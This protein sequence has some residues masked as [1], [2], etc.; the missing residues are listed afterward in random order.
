MPDAL[1]QRADIYIQPMRILRP[2]TP[3]FYGKRIRQRYLGIILIFQL[4]FILYNDSIQ[5]ILRHTIQNMI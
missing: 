4:V 1:N 3:F 2:L 5:F